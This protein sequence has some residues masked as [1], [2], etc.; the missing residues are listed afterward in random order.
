MYPKYCLFL[1]D[2]WYNAIV[3][4]NIIKIEQIKAEILGL[5]RQQAP[6]DSNAARFYGIE[7]KPVNEVEF[8][9]RCNSE[10]QLL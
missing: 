9:D 10:R 8:F 2:V 5:R 4:Y 7:R 3:M 1:R 6:R